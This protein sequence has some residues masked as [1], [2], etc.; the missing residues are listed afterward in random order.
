MI[1]RMAMM[2]R[3]PD[4]DSVAFNRYWLDIHGALVLRSPAV[5]RYQQNPVIDVVPCGKAVL[6]PFHFDG[7]VELW[8]RSEEDMDTCFESPTGRLLCDDEERFLSMITRHDVEPTPQPAASY[9]LLFAASGAQ[10]RTHLAVLA[11]RVA[12]CLD[13][14]VTGIVTNAVRG[15]LS[16]PNLP[17]EQVPADAFAQIFIDASDEFQARDIARQKGVI[18][19]L[20]TVGESFDRFGAYLVFERR[21]I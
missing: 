10:A 7:L 3:K 17:R 14:A 8:F 18:D 15:V 2:V 13:T 21:V 5:L 11:N 4:D 1:K 20:G 16:R 12:N 6:A 19:V 9:K